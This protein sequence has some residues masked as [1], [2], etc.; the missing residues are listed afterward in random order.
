MGEQHQKPQPCERGIGIAQAVKPC[1]VWNAK[2]TIQQS[3]K[4]NVSQANHEVN[5]AKS[6]ASPTPC[7]E[8]KECYSTKQKRHVYRLFIL[9]FSSKKSIIYHL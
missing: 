9:Q 3:K 8:C 5:K 2:N 6:S 7:L 4:L 1:H